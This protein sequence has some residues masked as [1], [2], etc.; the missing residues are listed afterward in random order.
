M[1]FSRISA[2]LVVFAA[3]PLTACSTVDEG[4][5]GLRIQ[6]YGPNAGAQNAKIL[7]PGGHF[8]NPFRAR[9]EQWPTTLQRYPFTA[10]SKEGSTENEA[11]CFSLGGTEACQDVAVPFRFVAQQLPKYYGEYKVDAST[12]IS[13]FLRDGLRD[14]YQ[15]VVDQTPS[16]TEVEQVGDRKVPKKGLSPLDLARQNS[17]IVPKVGECLQGKFPKVIEIRPLSA[18]SK[19]RFTA[20][21]IQEAIDEGF[22]AQQQAS[23]AVQKRVKAENEAA[24]QLAT[25]RGAAAA[26]IAEAKGAQSAE[27][28]AQQDHEYRMARVN[29]WDGREP[30]TIVNTPQAVINNGK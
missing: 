2:F 27:V 11:V 9:I 3:L 22:A 26:K 10:N 1:G 30:N 21:A 28:R 18:L 17:S 20:K 5:H 14:C 24:A 16:F 29:R 7:P 19:P 8:Y 6:K 4:F 25:A 13:G 23:S 15:T 12:F